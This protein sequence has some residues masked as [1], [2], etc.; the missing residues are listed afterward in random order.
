M[1]RKRWKEVRGWGYSRRK[2]IFL[3]SYL[4]LQRLQWFSYRIWYLI[5]KYKHK[6][7]GGN[8]ARCLICHKSPYWGIE[9]G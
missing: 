3:W 2:I 6:H 9:D 1:D 7:T 8:D 5:T 4:K